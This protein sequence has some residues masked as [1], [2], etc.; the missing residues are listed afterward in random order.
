MVIKPI[1]MLAPIPAAVATRQNGPNHAL[2]SASGTTTTHH[3][4]SIRRVTLA[5]MATAKATATMATAAMP[6]AVSAA[7]SN[8]TGLMK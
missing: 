1:P 6:I 8:G 7:G 2:A 4:L 5:Q 3:R